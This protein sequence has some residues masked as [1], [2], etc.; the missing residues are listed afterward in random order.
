MNDKSRFTFAELYDKRQI[1]KM[2]IQG[3]NSYI[4]RNVVNSIFVELF[5]AKLNE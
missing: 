5:L 1:Y 2:N 3:M 4:V